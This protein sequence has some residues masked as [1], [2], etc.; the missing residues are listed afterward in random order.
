M[1]ERTNT[2]H[3]DGKKWIISV[4]RDG[5]RRFF[6]S[7]TPGRTG[8]REAN[9]KADAWLKGSQASPTM[10]VS[11]AFGQWF[12]SL[13]SSTSKGHWKPLKSRWHCHVEP[14]I[15]SK[16]LCKLTEADLQAVINA[17]YKSYGLSAKTLQDLRADLTAF[18]KFCR[19]AQLSTLRP[20]DLSIPHSARRA[21]H[22]IL[23]PDDLRTLF[24]AD[25]TVIRGKLVQDDY[26]HAYRLAVL[27][28]LRPGELCALKWSDI[29]DGEIHVKRSINAN[30]EITQGKNQNAV[31][32]VTLSPL[33]QI[34]IDAQ[35]DM[36]G[37]FCN[38]FGDLTQKIY[39][40]R[41]YRYC[42]ANQ[43]PRCT[44]YE[45]RHTFV[46]VAKQL[47]EGMVKSLV[48][49]SASM[50]TFGVY[51]HALSGEKQQVSGAVDALFTSILQD[52]PPQK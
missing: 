6:Y 31:R 34:E 51:G 28:G 30:G 52:N 16:R 27:T 18:C 20:E 4:Q 47:P 26:I 45:L 10:T 8:Q 23:Q 48:G 33:A 22:S 15:G 29:Q 12:E 36:T 40:T 41:W 2:A 49:H 32:A 13:Q 35:R 46:S 19:R 44:P 3:W 38:V 5:K 9:A 7:S 50:D 25:Y 42:D 43:I 21:S 39:R 14:R 37:D 17:A 24:S 11:A 1:D